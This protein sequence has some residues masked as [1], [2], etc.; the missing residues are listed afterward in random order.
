VDSRR[1]ELNPYSKM[2]PRARKKVGSVFHGY[3]YWPFA[4]SVPTITATGLVGDNSG[5]A[6][7]WRT[8]H[9]LHVFI[10]EGESPK[11]AFDRTFRTMKEKYAP[12]KE[13][14]KKEGIPAKAPAHIAKEQSEDLEKKQTRAAITAPAEKQ[15]EQP[16]EQ[17]AIDDPNGKI[18]DS[19]ANLIRSSAPKTE[20][21]NTPEAQAAKRAWD[22]EAF[23]D[24]TN[25]DTPGGK[26]LWDYVKTK[27][28]SRSDALIGKIASFRSFIGDYTRYNSD[29]WTA[30]I[31]QY[32][33][34]GPA[35]WAEKAKADP[36]LP[37]YRTVPMIVSAFRIAPSTKSVMYRGVGSD[38]PI[39]EFENLKEGSEFQLT[40]ARSFSYKREIATQFMGGKNEKYPYSYMFKV[41]KGARALNAA[42]MSTEKE[43]EAIS[44]GKFQITGV[45]RQGRK[46]VIKMSQTG[47][48]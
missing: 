40:G 12:L 37:T 7:V 4:S 9:G 8:I 16:T 10:K 46:M 11:D 25:A 23:K 19:L 42:W 43:E 34:E 24:P 3:G 45:E 41:E 35:N 32:V 26:R 14:S 18:P 22:N 13:P 27:G 15:K 48:Y 28:A 36:N 38:T 33:T 29:R 6:G 21:A 47:V 20:D 5:E 39:A 31:S 30:A 44:Y 2:I 17:G 1:R